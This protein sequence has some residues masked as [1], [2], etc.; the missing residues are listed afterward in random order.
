VGLGFIKSNPKLGA[1]DAEGK[2]VLFQ[3]DGDGHVT[4]AM[5]PGFAAIATGMGA[6]MFWLSYRNHNLGMG[7]KK[8]AYH[9][10]EAKIMAET[11]PF[12][13]DQIDLIIANKEKHYIIK[14][15]RPNPEGIPITVPEL[16][17]LL[18]KYGPRE[19]DDLR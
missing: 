14:R 5:F 1:F 17:K 4:N 10:F 15:N 9:A 18:R 2:P 7:V 3:L 19:T 13:N 16:R 11:S 8:A 12:V 6:A